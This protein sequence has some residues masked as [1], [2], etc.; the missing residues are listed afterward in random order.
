MAEQ[1][2]T[3]ELAE[4]VEAADILA[5]D[6]NVANLQLLTGLLKKQGHHV[7]PVT[8][9][10]L[11][12][13]AARKKRPDLILLDINMPEMDG[14]EVCAQLKAD[15]ELAEIPVIFISALSDMLDKV[16]AFESG[17]VDYITKPFE[18]REV[19]ARVHTHLRIRR[20]QDR[21]KVRNRQLR[22]KNR[23]LE[24]MA[25]LED[26][27]VS[28]I[29]H[30]L[31]APLAGIIGYFELLQINSVGQL[32]EEYREDIDKGLAVAQQMYE[33]I[34][35]LL[36]VSRLEKA[37]MPMERKRCDLT[38]LADEAMTSLE[39]LAEYRQFRT[40][41]A[42]R[43]VRVHCD[44]ALIR[45]VMINYLHN[46][47]KFTSRNGRISLSVKETD[48]HARI[49]VEDDGPPIPE[50]YEEKVFDKFGLSDLKTGKGGRV[51]GLG[52]TFCK[53]CVEAHG[54]AVGVERSSEGGSR[55]WFTLPTAEPQ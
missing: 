51:P 6:D 52:L 54:G 47:L 5:V 31:R 55:F 30:D 20:L 21:L 46:A 16:K 12:L 9:G 3:E 23:K 22:E 34:N 36:D 28:L 10:K 19:R 17:G 35:S 11:A 7:R 50:G 44:P 49:E 53:L 15:R 42:D 39:S 13:S 8:E 29:I 37:E 26:Q 41:L 48:G 43:G 45:R 18:F 38:E 27:L 4:A 14:F 40:D 33:V 24:E 32:A 1:Q 2:R 25:E